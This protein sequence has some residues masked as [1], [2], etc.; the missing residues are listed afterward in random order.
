MQYQSCIAYYVSIW[1]CYVNR[2]KMRLDLFG[3][4]FRTR[5]QEHNAGNIVQL[6]ATDKGYEYA[7]VMLII[8]KKH[9][10]EDLYEN[11]LTSTL[12]I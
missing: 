10:P 2:G 12:Q 8:A 7:I 9:Y 4:R 3:T 6:K 5:R 1:C 11:K